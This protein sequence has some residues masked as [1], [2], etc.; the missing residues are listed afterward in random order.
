MP[1]VER[2]GE[3]R[4]YIKEDSR[5]REEDTPESFEERLHELYPGED[6]KAY[7]TA[8][9]RISQAIVYAECYSDES[10]EVR[11]M[12][13]KDEDG[14]LYM[15]QEYSDNLKSVCNIAWYYLEIRGDNWEEEKLRD[16]TEIL[17]KKKELENSAL[18]ITIEELTEPTKEEIDLAKER[19]VAE[20]LRLP[21]PNASEALKYISLLCSGPIDP[22]E[23]FSDF[24]TIVPASH[25]MGVY[26]IDYTDFEKVYRRVLREEYC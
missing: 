21:I 25:E 18:D 3:A 23:L 20:Y 16:H 24:I 6:Q 1:D 19:I 4:E 26:H 17:S 7:I 8:L 15:S 14:T 22:E 10:V 12:Y 13:T 2:L 9:M 5:L 11:R